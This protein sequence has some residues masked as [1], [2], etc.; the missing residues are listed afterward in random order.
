M[1]DSIAGVTPAAVRQK[2]GGTGNLAPV[3]AQTDVRPWWVLGGL[4][5]SGF[6]LALPGG[7]LPLWGYHIHTEFGTAGNYF[8]A[9]GAGVIGG[10]ALAQ[11]WSRRL[12]LGRLL[13][14]GCFIAALALLMLSLAAPPAQVWYQMIALL[15][16]GAAAGVLNTGV[17]ESLT[18]SYES[19][20]AT[21]TLSAGIFFGAG[22]V[23][24]SFLLS[25]SF[26]DETA[27]RLLAV[28]AIVPGVSAGVFAFRRIGRGEVSVV[29]IPQAMR[30]LRSGLAILFALLLFFQFAN[31]WSI[32]GWLPVF[33]IDR[34]GVS[35]AT[36]VTLL[37]VYWVALMAG[38]IATS[39]L[40]A[41]VHHGRLLGAS[42]FG[43]LF[44][45]VLLLASGGRFG[46]IVGLLLA[47]AGFSAIYPLAA[48]SIAS[49]FT[50]YHPGY[51]NGIFTFALMG[52]ILAPFALGHLAAG[53]GLRVVP[54]AVMAGSVAVF[55]LVLLIWLGRKVSGH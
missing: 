1:V 16:S 47:G 11:R 21:I 7:L 20:P 44:G 19:N 48:E 2:E 41:F 6:L 26:E 31:E 28:S 3:R 49:R 22:S 29:S 33:L 15:V 39:K 45:C 40:L 36:A 23:L 17:F 10:G 38:R 54:L 53:Y 35:P 46:V 12:E 55:I 13:S 14:A 8:L 4:L 37:A 51:F 42:A 5:I 34:L 50:Y 27:T 32:A 43:A 30:D 25:R 24:A 52:G 9:L 18:A